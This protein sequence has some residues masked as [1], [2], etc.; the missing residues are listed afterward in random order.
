MKNASF[1]T[2]ATDIAF[3]G[4]GSLMTASCGDDPITVAANDAGATIDATS[5]SSS[6]SGSL[7]SGPPAPTCTDA[8]KNGAE[9]DIDCG[10]T[11]TTKCATGKTCGSSDD[12]QVGLLCNDSKVCVEPTCADAVKNGTETDID[13]GGTCASKCADTKSC[14]VAADCVSSV[15]T[16]NKCL[17]ATCTDAAKNGTETDVDCGG[18]CATKCADTKNCAVAADCMSSVCTANKCISTA[19]A[20]AD[21]VKNG[22]ETD[23][24]CG[25][26]CA[27]KC[28]DTKDCAV[29][30]DCMSSVCTANKCIS[31]AAAC[32]DTVK[33]GTET[34]VDCGGACATK[35]GFDKG[36]NVASDC[37]SGICTANK[38]AEPKAANLIGHWTFG[39]AE[40]LKELTGNWA[41]LGFFGTGSSVASGRLRVQP[42]GY[43]R[44]TK[45]GAFAGPLRE[46][47]LVSWV[48][49]QALTPRAGS[50]ITIDSPSVD[51]FDGI[52][53]SENFTDNRWQSGSNGGTRN[54]V[55]TTVEVLNVNQTVQLAIAYTPSVNNTQVSM[56][57]CRN[58]V[59]EVVTPAGTAALAE[60]TG[61]DAEI[62]F[63]ARHTAPGQIG[64][65]DA[66]ID[67]ARIYNVA[68]T[69][70][71][72]ALLTRR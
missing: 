52:I 25:G 36:C 21:T 45:V 48:S 47:T 66:F 71:E 3:A 23:V 1:L 69:C 20:C 30:A 60:W 10:G 13:C 29:A 58:G 65:M 57:I 33:N 12:C 62:L 68:L 49:L 41:D 16:A 6:S 51:K 38:C 34:D 67:E 55:A 70:A 17:A 4:I 31:T 26:A 59:E 54:R 50:A 22:T 2:V 46:K 43:A 24:D 42:T 64:G 14:A 39:G 53:F 5:S 72:V 40:P 44:A 19:A 8:Q 61:T 15:C 56:R 27:T 35:C 63:G 9:T 7:D 18:T 32:A 28:A 37:A 11:C